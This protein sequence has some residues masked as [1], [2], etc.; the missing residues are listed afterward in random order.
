MKTL[1][2]L[3]ALLSYPTADLMAAH[4]ELCMVL[5][6][7][8]VLPKPQRKALQNLLDDLATARAETAARQWSI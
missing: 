8:A 6:Q 1:K 4:D 2:V 5:E 7:E 3:S